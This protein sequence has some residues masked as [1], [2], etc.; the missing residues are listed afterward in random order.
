MGQTETYVDPYWPELF[1]CCNYLYLIYL[2]FPEIN[3]RLDTI[4]G[5]DS[6]MLQQLALQEERNANHLRELRRDV[7]G[8]KGAR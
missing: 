4:N 1:V 7:K 8:M 3:R 6:F 2:L 5:T